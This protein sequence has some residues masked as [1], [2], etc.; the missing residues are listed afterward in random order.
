[1][2]HIRV[3]PALTSVDVLA[4]DDFGLRPLTPEL[5]RD[6]Y[7]LIREPLQAQGAHPDL[8]PR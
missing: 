5:A 6:L 7:D 2:E 1:V 4:L 8:D 3:A